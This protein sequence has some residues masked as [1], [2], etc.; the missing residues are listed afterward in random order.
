MQHLYIRTRITMNPKT[1]PRTAPMTSP[2]LSVDLAAGNVGVLAGTGAVEVVAAA[3]VGEDVASP[4][5][6]VVVI[7]VVARVIVSIISTG[8]VSLCLTSRRG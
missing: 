5:S 6:I 7:V 1:E 3:F 4:K 2:L 8:E